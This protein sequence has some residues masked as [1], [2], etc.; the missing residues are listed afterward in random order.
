MPTL[1]ARP[2]TVCLLGGCLGLAACGRTDH[3]ADPP[4]A[5][6]SPAQ[7]GAGPSSA[8]GPA[9]HQPTEF[10]AYPGDGAGAPTEA[11]AVAA[12]AA[13]AAAGRKL[14]QLVS[15]IKAAEKQLAAADQARRKAYDTWVQQDRAYLDRRQT[16]EQELA[17]LTQAGRQA[18]AERKRAELAS[19]QAPSQPP[20]PPPTL[21]PQEFNT[22]QQAWRQRAALGRTD[23]AMAMFDDLRDHPLSF[24]AEQMQL[25]RSDLE[26]FR[27][28]GG[29]PFLAGL[30]PELKPR[31]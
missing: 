30:P 2:L 4:P 11:A 9:S 8:P 14:D 15:D 18:E 5:P 27:Q 13:Q 20:A 28:Q 10:G 22:W 17:Q 24:S 1:P 29:E 26:I 23:E 12:A 31:Q 25:I 6:V 3:P 16:L 19:L 21:P 7:P